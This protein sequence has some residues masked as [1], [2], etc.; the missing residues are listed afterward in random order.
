M[1]AG[2]IQLARLNIVTHHERRKLDARFQNVIFSNLRHL[3]VIVFNEDGHLRG[4]TNL[5]GVCCPQL[6]TL[7]IE[8]VSGLLLSNCVHGLP[9]EW[10]A[11]FKRI[12]VR[13]VSM[14]RS[15][16]C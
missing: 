14:S 8:G 1:Y 5:P 6:S 9:E 15:T 7:E 10:R 3:K 13:S 12:A 16:C 4:C 11:L 2:L